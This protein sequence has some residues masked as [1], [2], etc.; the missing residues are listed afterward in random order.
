MNLAITIVLVATHAVGPTP[1]SVFRGAHHQVP[2]AAVFVAKAKSSIAKKK[3]S[4]TPAPAKAGVRVSTEL[5]VVE[6]KEKG[7]R[8]TAFVVK[9]NEQLQAT[10]SGQGKLA[11]VVYQVLSGDQATGNVTANVNLDGKA[12]KPITFK[13]K[14]TST[15]SLVGPDS[16]SV[17]SPTSVTLAIATGSHTLV[18]AIP[19][20]STGAVI[21]LQHYPKGSKKAV[22]V[23]VVKSTP[24]AVVEAPA[25]APIRPPPTE[26]AAAP[27]APGGAATQSTEDLIKSGAIRDGLV[28]TY[29]EVKIA[30]AEAN[31]STIFYR[32]SPDAPFQFMVDGPGVVTVSVHRLIVAGSIAARAEKLTILENDVLLQAVDV[33]TM[34]SERYGVADVPGLRAAGLREY[35]LTI[36]TKLAR[37]AFQP[38]DTAT[39]GMAMR[40]AFEPQ[41]KSPALALTLELGDDSGGGSLVANTTVTEVAVRENVVRV[42]K[43]VRVAGEGGEFLGVG[44]GGGVVTPTWG[45]RPAPTADLEVRFSLPFAKR[46]F[47]IGLNVGGLRQDLRVNIAD[48]QGGS[49]PAGS[50]A[51]VFPLTGSFITRY[52]IGN[53]F[54]VYLDLGGGIAYVRA[55]TDVGPTSHSAAAWV[56]LLRGG[57]GPEVRLGPG[58]LA[59]DVAYLWSPAQR[60]AGVLNDYAPTGV[61]T[62]ARYRLGF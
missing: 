56:P 45:G 46:R 41:E 14:M 24:P 17:T 7:R 50:I 48:P 15:V 51:L 32:A 1:A 27:M 61:L 55:T 25:P 54:A 28:G 31:T 9:P 62:T 38:P 44:L 3:P 43:V 34:P 35:R 22:P 4:S 42:E 36:A 58:W 37:L 20:S 47:A 53:W 2:A 6:V 40:Y 33:D 10:V 49:I 21:E 8:G 59:L 11:V 29:P 13:G 26:L 57:G 18:V 23:E 30:D 16:P 19:A 60:L 52:P 39:Q 5:P 12:Q